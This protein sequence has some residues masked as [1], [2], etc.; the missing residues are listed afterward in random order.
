MIPTRTPSGFP[1]K[2]TQGRNMA[3]LG[4]GEKEGVGEGVGEGE[5][6]RLLEKDKVGV[7]VEVR[8][9]ELGE[10]L[11]L[12]IPLPKT[13]PKTAPPKI[14]TKTET[15]RDTFHQFGKVLGG[16]QANTRTCRGALSDCIYRILPQHFSGCCTC[17]V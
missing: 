10:S 17:L 6:V 4:E 14:S 8:V 15:A 12:R 9:K 13:P 2:P 3:G 11:P 5:G 1:A 7:G 16:A